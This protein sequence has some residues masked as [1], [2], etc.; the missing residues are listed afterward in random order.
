[1]AASTKTKLTL[2]L[3]D[4]QLRTLKPLL[5]EMGSVKIAGEIHGGALNV[6]F[7]ACNAAFLACNAAFSIGGAKQV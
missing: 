1:M 7:L 3:S 2:K 6:S 5:D 4:E